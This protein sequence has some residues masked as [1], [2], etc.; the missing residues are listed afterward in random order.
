MAIVG[1]NAASALVGVP[2]IPIAGIAWE[3]FP[4]MVYMGLLGW[5]TFNPIT[6]GATFILAC[7]VNAAIESLVLN[8][9]FK[10][11]LRRQ[12]F[13]WLVAANSLSVGAAFASL[14]I[15]PVEP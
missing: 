14:F 6:W 3:F 4:G 7:L 11:P 1:A 13:F 12:E 10:L 5:G 9:G 15:V 2:L 8:R